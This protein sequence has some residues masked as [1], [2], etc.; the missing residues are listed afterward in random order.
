MMPELI[1]E[2][3]G[4]VMTAV[5][6]IGTVANSLRKRCGFYFWGVSNTFWL[7]Y[8]ILRMEYASALLYGFNLMMAFVGLWRWRK[9]NG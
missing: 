2:I 9:D 3:L 6:I 7:L 4:Y 1:L 5:A 8:M